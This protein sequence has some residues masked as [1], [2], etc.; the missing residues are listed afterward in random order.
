MSIR[1][2]LFWEE[3]QENMTRERCRKAL[4][5]LAEL[6]IDDFDYKNKPDDHP[7][8]GL[9]G[10]YIRLGHVRDARAALEALDGTHAHPSQTRASP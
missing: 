10:H 3:Q 7:I 9:N 2:R 8:F 5:G 4:E 6:P 1:D